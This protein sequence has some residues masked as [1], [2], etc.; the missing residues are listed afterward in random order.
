MQRFILKLL[1]VDDVDEDVEN[2]LDESPEL[3][4]QGRIK[5][6]RKLG[7]TRN[8]PGQA[9]NDTKGG[10]ALEANNASSNEDILK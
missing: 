2:D 3:E 8:T 10:N 1:S 9:I 6:Y 5:Q 4:Q 7:N